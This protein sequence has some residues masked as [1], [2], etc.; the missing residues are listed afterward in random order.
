MYTVSS[1]GVKYDFVFKT[2]LD[3]LIFL[4]D[5]LERNDIDDPKTTIKDAVKSFDGIIETIYLDNDMIT[6]EL[7]KG[8][9]ETDYCKCC[10]CDSSMKVEN[11]TKCDHPVCLEC[12]NK[13]R[14]PKCPMCRAPIESKLVTDDVLCGIM[15][16]EA[17]DESEAINNDA[18][19]AMMS[20]FAQELDLLIAGLS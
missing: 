5:E 1:N 15:Q 19:M 20:S 9:V 3:A 7:E 18:E 4:I 11:K 13:L 12:L 17:D 16:R 2:K 6:I 14:K 8:E 10:V